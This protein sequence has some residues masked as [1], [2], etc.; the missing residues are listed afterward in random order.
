MASV[1]NAYRMCLALLKQDST[2]SVYPKLTD[3]EYANMKWNLTSVIPVDYDFTN[4]QQGD[5]Q[6]ETVEKNTITVLTKAKK[7]ESGVITPPTLSFNSMTPADCASVTATLDAITNVDD[8]FKVLFLAGVF[9]SESTGVRTY[10]VFNACVA[11]LT[12]DGG[13]SGEAKA[14][15][16]G[17]LSLQACHLPIIGK[18]ECGAQL[19]WT[20]SSGVVAASFSN[21][22]GSGS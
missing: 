15:F 7:F 1:T 12:G 16:T 5:T 17:T 10:D 11:I 22:S 19:T 3:P 6:I 9:N 20:T 2:G 8:P 4:Y 21:G 18:T 13:R 14:T